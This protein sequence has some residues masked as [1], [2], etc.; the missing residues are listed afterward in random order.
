[1]PQTAYEMRISDWSSDVCSSDLK[2]RDEELD[3]EDEES[4][5]HQQPED[6]KHRDRQEIAEKLR[7]ARHLRYLI[8]QRVR[9][10]EAGAGDRPGMQQIVGRYASAACRDAEAGEAAE[11]N[12]GKGAEVADDEGEGPDIEH[13]LDE[14]AQH[15]LVVV[16]RPPERGQGH[17][18]A[19][20]YGGKKGDIARQ[21]PEPAVDVA[22]EG[23][24]EAVDDVEVGVH[25]KALCCAWSVA[26]V[27]RSEGRASCRER[28][29]P[30][31]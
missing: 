1:M 6:E 13:L 31:V 23:F 29:V 27:V 22:Y 24:E 7:E 16:H 21:Q 28:V 11:N 15:I 18:D 26:R 19:D 17:V 4:E 8:E 2:E 10:G 3:G 12:I 9:G 20:Q 14:L 30:Y 5:Q 25:G